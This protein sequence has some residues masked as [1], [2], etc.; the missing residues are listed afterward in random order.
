VPLAALGQS[1]TPQTSAQTMK[2]KALT[3]QRMF[4]RKVHGIAVTLL[5]SAADG[6]V[7]VEAFQNHLIVRVTRD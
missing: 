3:E 6:K 2:I 5:Q 7:A 1:S 4:R